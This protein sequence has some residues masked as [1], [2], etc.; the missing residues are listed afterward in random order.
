MKFVQK[1]ACFIALFFLG[2]G[3]LF[4]CKDKDILSGEHDPGKPTVFSDFSP[5][6]GAI[7]TRL[8]ISG[9]NF[10]TD[11]SKIRVFIG[12]RELKVVGA[13]GKQIYCWVPGQTSTGQVRVVIEGGSGKTV[14]HTFPDQFNYIRSTN[15]G[16]LVGN[17]DQNGNSGIIDGDFETA[18]FEYPAWV[19][20]EP[21]SNVLFVTELDRAVR[22]VDL[23]ARTVSTLVTNGQAAFA[24]M[25]TTTLSPD[26]DTL[27]LVDDNGNRS[28]PNKVA[29]AYTLRSENYRRVHAL[30]WDVGAYGVAPH[31]THNGLFYTVT[32]GTPIKKAVPD[33][34][35]GEL[36]PKELYRIGGNLSTLIFFHPSGNYA[37]VMAHTRIYKSMYNWDTRELQPAIIFAGDGAAGD[38][39]AIGTSARMG[40]AYQGVF[41]KNPAYAGQADE[42]DFYF[43]DQ[44]NHSIRILAPNGMVTTFAGKGSPTPDGTKYG[45]IDGDPRLEARFNQ[46][47]GIDYDVANKT[48]YVAERNNKRIR[49]ITVE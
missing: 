18:R 15:V 1:N 31:P 19:T 29:I 44:N 42:Y 28:T 16:T 30:L 39:D 37:Y 24:K 23:G 40:R 9:E 21:G 38:V 12:D 32:N 45:Y 14:E 17:V 20:F 26:T 3:F 41:V 4:S 43:C 6:K 36:V 27:F 46:P 10:G 47:T 13:N 7:R 33:A 35:T 22:K 5:K 34:V 49:T 2:V 48:F 11:V 8:Y 25:Q